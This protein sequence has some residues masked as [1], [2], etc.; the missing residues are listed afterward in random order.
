[1][2][3]LGM[4]LLPTGGV[5]AFEIVHAYLR[6]PQSFRDFETP[7]PSGVGTHSPPSS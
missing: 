7:L 5:D 6:S 2:R 1:M 3:G 4:F